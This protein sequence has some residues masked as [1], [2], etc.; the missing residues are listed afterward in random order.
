[1]TDYPIP[2]ALDQDTIDAIADDLARL[3]TALVGKGVAPSRIANILY[4]ATGA[5]TAWELGKGRQL[6]RYTG[7]QQE[8]P[9][10]A[11]DGLQDAVPGGR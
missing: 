3:D 8:A 1:M 10:Q 9:R 11:R 7:A 6:R 2:A 4:A 5:L